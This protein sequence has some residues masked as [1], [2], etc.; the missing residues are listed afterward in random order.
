MERYV[1][2]TNCL[3]MMLSSRSKYHKLWR[4]FLHKKY[5]IVI[6]NEILEEYLEVVS[7][8]L[9]TDIAEYL[10]YVLINSSN[11]IKIDPSYKFQLI[12]ADPDDNKF[13]DCAACGNAKLIVTNDK[14]FKELDKDVFP[15]V[16]HA[17]IDAFYEI[18]K[19]TDN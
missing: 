12:Q 15:K 4:D 10:A 5:A 19:R 7:R 1:L 2:D 13:V 16:F 9:R 11:V 17:D 3:I 6:S 18:I 8:N 14:H